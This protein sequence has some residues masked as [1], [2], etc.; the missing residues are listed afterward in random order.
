[1]THSYIELR[2]KEPQI[3]I[4]ARNIAYEFTKRLTHPEH[5][6]GER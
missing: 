3:I 5:L 6:K 4:L 2:D 1:M